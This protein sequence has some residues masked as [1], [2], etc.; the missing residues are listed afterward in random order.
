MKLLHH[1][2]LKFAG[3][4]TLIEMLIVIA[5][6]AILAGVVLTGVS[7]FQASARDTRRIGDLRNVQNF[8]ELYFN[9]CGFYPGSITGG[10][11]T[12]GATDW[13]GLK[14][15]MEAEGFTS[16]FPNDPVA[17][18]TYYYGVSSDNLQ[19][20]VG[21][22]LE[23]QNSALDDDVDGTVYGVDCSD[24]NLRYCVRS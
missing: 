20:V 3:G 19:Y 7:G 23:R 13:N 8:L 5:V 9:R 10:S 6:I 17:G 18:R 15:M 11:C 22:A 4:F 14:A 21:A 2:T 1:K 24:V 12:T 16:N